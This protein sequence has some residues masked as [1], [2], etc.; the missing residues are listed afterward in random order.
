MARPLR[1]EFPDAWCHVMN[2][3]R[4]GEAIFADD[5]DY[6][7]FSARVREASEM[8]NI[9]IAAYCLMPNHYHILIQTPDANDCRGMELAIQDIHI[10][11]AIPKSKRLVAALPELGSGGGT[12]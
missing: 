6:S 8:W 12:R 7:R 3:G 1:I 2:R 5:Q 4:R 11:S 9:R 10:V